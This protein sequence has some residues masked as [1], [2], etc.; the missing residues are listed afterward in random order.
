MC[1]SMIGMDDAAVLDA[2]CRGAAR[3]PERAMP[4]AA[5]TSVRNLRRVTI[6]QS[7]ISIPNPQSINSAIRNPKS[8]LYLAH[9]YASTR[10]SAP[11]LTE[12]VFASTTMPASEPIDQGPAA[13]C[14]NLWPF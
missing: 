2:D 10:G 3:G 9:A 12:P 5:A 11:A 1:V 7:Q 8:A 14:G 4:L 13:R 6:R